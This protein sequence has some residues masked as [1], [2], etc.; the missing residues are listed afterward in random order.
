MFKLMPMYTWAFTI[1]SVIMLTVNEI[2]EYVN[3]NFFILLW[4]ISVDSKA[5]DENAKI[6][7]EILQMLKDL[8]MF[9]QQIPPEYGN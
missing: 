2:Y 3:D 7:D 4:L 6:P 8:G 5:I 1:M 9:G